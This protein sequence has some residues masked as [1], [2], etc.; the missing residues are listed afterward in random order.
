LIRATAVALTLLALAG[1]ALAQASRHDLAVAAVAAGFEPQLSKRIM[2]TY[3]PA[4]LDLIKLR[5]PQAT[6]I[7]LFQ[8]QGKITTFADDAAKAA[9]APMIGVLEEGF[10][11][12]ELQVLIE[13]YQSPA[14]KKLNLAA[15]PI[16]AT[17]AG[18]VTANLG[19]EVAGLQGKIDAMLTADGH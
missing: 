17:M 10:S 7:E 16:A 11:P 15:G 14:G 9:L 1:P 12:A 4:A 6:D 8:Y 5:H 19:P 3:W 13:F 2:D 18:P